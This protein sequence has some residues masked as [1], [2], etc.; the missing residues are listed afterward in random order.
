MRAALSNQMTTEKGF[1]FFCRLLRLT[2]R[3]NTEQAEALR[4]LF[5]ASGS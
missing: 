3:E 5:G 4:R 1:D 2:L